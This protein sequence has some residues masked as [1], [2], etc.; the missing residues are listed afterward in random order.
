M[1]IKKFTAY[2][3]MGT[4]IFLN[5]ANRMMQVAYTILGIR[6]TNFTI[7]NTFADLFTS[8]ETIDTLMKDIEEFEKKN[9][10][11][12]A[13]YAVEGMS[14]MDEAKILEFYTQMIESITQ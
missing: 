11:C 7:N 14:T 4:E 2:K 8:G 12:I 10:S 13:N 3:L 9:I 6:L 1:L 5:H